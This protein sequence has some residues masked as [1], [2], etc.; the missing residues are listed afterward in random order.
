M[1][2]EEW[3]RKLKAE[4]DAARQKKSESA[5]ILHG[6]RG[7][8]KDDELKLKA[9]RD[10]ERKKAQDAQQILH[11]YKGTQIADGVVAKS[12]E[13]R[14]EQ[15]FP[16]PVNA[17]QGPNGVQLDVIAPGSVSERAAAL[18][19]AAEGASSSIPVSSAHSTSRN[20]TTGGASTS[21]PADDDDDDDDDDDFGPSL[22][23]TSDTPMMSDSAVLQQPVSSLLNDVTQQPPGGSTPIEESV[24]VEK[25]LEVISNGA[26]TVEGTTAKQP[27]QRIDVLLAFGLVT[28][29]SP[30]NLE[31]YMKAVETIAT[32]SIQES[33]NAEGATLDP[34]CPPYVQ[35]TKWDG[36]HLL[37]CCFP[38]TLASLSNNHEL[39]L[40]IVV[41]V[42]I[43]GIESYVSRSGRVDVKRLVVTVA[44]P[45][46]VPGTQRVSKS[47]VKQTKEVIA[48]T[49]QAAI[50]SGD[51]LSHAQH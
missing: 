19:A 39:I 20:A 6:Y 29:S 47:S 7:D 41:F 46:F 5:E 37:F 45:I 40:N 30:P 17:G 49:L 24:M 18:A 16:I 32:K 34:N 25:S 14:T 28:I 15:H 13:Q 35:D 4:K 33:S 1:N 9:I 51:F 50:A 8:L 21:I 23:P 12:K 26:T 10:E 48:S 3:Q 31:A 36:T 44:V 11:N 43:D 27:L 2:M 42:V 38:T 22:Q